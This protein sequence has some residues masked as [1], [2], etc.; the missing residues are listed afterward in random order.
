MD[1]RSFI[2]LIQ[3]FIAI[4]IQ[5][6]N[7]LAAS[8]KFWYVVFLFAFILKY[9]LLIYTLTLWLFRR[10]FN[11]HIFVNFPLFLISHLIPYS[12][13]FQS[14][15]FIEDWAIRKI[16]ITS[17]QIGKERVKYLYFQISWCLA[18]ARTF[19]TMLHR[20]GKSRHLCLV[21]DLV[22]KALSLSPLNMMFTYLNV[23]FV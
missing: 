7:T 13:W 5:I 12:V 2:F 9:F 22:G 17:I 14:F 21:L 3:V 6:S 16:E 23:H 11:F 8:H 1:L 20:S 10:V 15:S 4:N 18:Q 19:S